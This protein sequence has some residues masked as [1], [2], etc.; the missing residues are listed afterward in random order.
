MLFVCVMPKRKKSSLSSGRTRRLRPARE[1]S[2]DRPL[3]DNGVSTGP[4]HSSPRAIE[5]P[6][7]HTAP[8]RAVR[9][10]V[11]AA[12]AHELSPVR[13]SRLEADRVSVSAARA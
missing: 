4:S 11:N 3:Q 8:L 12:R 9:G 5:S 7:V 6:P 2:A 1:P 13:R 10:F